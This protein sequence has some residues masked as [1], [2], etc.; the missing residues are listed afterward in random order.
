MLFTAVN[1]N[2]L[3]HLWPSYLGSC[4]WMIVGCG[5]VSLNALQLFLNNCRMWHRVTG[6]F[7]A[8]P[9]YCMM[10]HRVTGR[11]EAFPHYCRMWHRVTG[12]FEAFPHYCRMWHRVT[13]RFEAFPHYCRMWHCVT[14]RVVLISSWRVEVSTTI[15][16]RNFSQQTNSHCSPHPDTMETT[17]T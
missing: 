4:F 16:S 3:R 8:F 9:H 2:F 10:W 17:A 13:G 12:R 11:F 7:E 15:L 6:R 14:G 1:Q 5:T